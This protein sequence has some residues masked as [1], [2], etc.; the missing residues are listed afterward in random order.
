MPH[1]LCMTVV[2]MF[3]KWLNHLACDDQAILLYPLECGDL[4]HPGMQSLVST[5][6]VID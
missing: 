6:Y 3:G 1:G 5:W 2:Q 4:A